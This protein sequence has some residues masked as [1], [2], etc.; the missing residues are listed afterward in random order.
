[1]QWKY[2]DHIF[3][4]ILIHFSEKFEN[5]VIIWL[6]FFIHRPRALNR[7]IMK[8]F[9]TVRNSMKISGITPN[10]VSVGFYELKHISTYVL[11]IMLGF[12]YPYNGVGSVTEYM[13]AILSTVMVMLVL[14]AYLNFKL[15]SQEIFKMLD[16]FEQAINTSEYELLHL[17]LWTFR[18]IT[19]ICISVFSRI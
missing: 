9:E 16:G 12:L 14:I 15:K 7:S 8:I 5:T 2:S 3:L 11:G 1:M 6:F 13:E 10:R 4:S 19:R 18:S 17:L